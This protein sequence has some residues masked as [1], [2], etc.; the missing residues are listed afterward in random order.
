MDKGEFSQSFTEVY[1]R[2]DHIYYDRHNVL[3][4]LYGFDA[5]RSERTHSP[6]LNLINCDFKYFFDMQALI[7]VETN[8]YFEAGI[9]YSSEADHHDASENKF[10]GIAG[11]DRGA[12]INITSS[13]FKHSKFCKGLITYRKE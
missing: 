3:F 13:T 6:E 2:N 11:E 10:M 5:Y 8:N 9:D 4:N 12:R 7:Q 1:W